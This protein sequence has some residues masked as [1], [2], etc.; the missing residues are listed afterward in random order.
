M[1]LLFV[2]LMLAIAVD[3]SPAD[4]PPSER[5]LDVSTSW[6]GNSFPGGT[7]QSKWVQDFIFA[8]AVNPAGRCFTISHWDEAHREAGIYENGDVIGNCEKAAGEAVAV[9]ATHAFA[10]QG[11]GVRRYTFEGAPTGTFFDLG[12]SPRSIAAS[13]EVLAATDPANDRVEIYRI[14]DAS[15]LHRFEV[16]DPGAV[17]L[18]PNGDLW[19]VTPIAR[20]GFDGRYWV[21]DPKSPPRIVRYSK[22]GKR[23]FEAI[24][25]YPDWIPASLAFDH[26]GRLVVGDNGPRR[27]VHFFDVSEEP[28]LVRSFG[29]RG[30]IGA[31]KPGVVTPTKFWGITGAAT[32]A[33]GNL[34]VSMYEQGSI[35][36]AFTRKG[37]LLWEVMAL[38]FVDMNDADPASDGEHVYGKQEHYVMD[39]TKPAGKQGTFHG[40]SLDSVKYP[41]DPRL[42]L[43]NKDH[44]IASPLMRRLNGG[45]LYM[46]ATGMYA[47]HFVVYRYEGEIAVPSVM[48]AKEQWKSEATPGWPPNQPAEGGWIWRDADGDGRFDADEYRQPEDRKAASGD[49]GW[50]VDSKGD[51]WQTLSSPARLRRFPLQGFDRHGN[52]V[53]TWE[54]AQVMPAPAPFTS[55]KRVEYFPETDTI[56]L[57]GYTAE[58]P[59]DPSH[60]KEMGRVL[61]RYDGW[62]KGNRTAKWTTLLNWNSGPREV[63]ATP[64]S[65]SVAGDYVFVTHFHRGGPIVNRVYRATTGEPVGIFKPGPEIN[66]VTGDVDIPYGIRAFRRRNGEYLI[67][68]EDDRYAKVVLYRW[69][70]KE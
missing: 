50:W 46:Y 43:T 19:M 53:Y 9:N 40:Y 58:Q 62:A 13:A 68:Q 51:V 15:R 4:S 38:N 8:L 32:D 28:N 57:S 7:R 23:E 64:H 47:S 10:P 17:A 67:F 60:W 42:W 5:L 6:T 27:Q 35:L 61:A 12:Y 56:Y 45:K 59:Y 1:I 34:Y 48:F 2:I 11:K 25:G 14:S 54:S 69:T 63:Y 52:P 18:A 3:A 44:H 66:G 26:Q 70:P 16:N 36:R 37:K 65:M 31:G 39:Y 41:E 24:D 55:L 29:E 21:A 20:Q 22:E 33:K 30:G 49:W